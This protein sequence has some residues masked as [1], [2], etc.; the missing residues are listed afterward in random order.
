L[1]SQMRRSAESVPSNIAESQ[2]GASGVEFLQFLG[3][4]RGSL[5]GLETQIVLASKL[6]YN[7][8]VEQETTLVEAQHLGRI[9]N[10]LI[11]SLKS[12]SKSPAY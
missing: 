12:G 1:K 8:A 11:A 7:S 2:G 10:G 6:G 3:H 5:Y 4:S 9:L